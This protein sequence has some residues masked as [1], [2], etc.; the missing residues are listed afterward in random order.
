SSLRKGK[1]VMSKQN[2]VE[3]EDMVLLAKKIERHLKCEKATKLNLGFS[4]SRTSNWNKDENVE[5]KKKIDS[6]NGKHDAPNQS[7][8]IGDITI[9][10]EYSNKYSFEKDGRKLILTPLTSQKVYED[11]IKLQTKL[12]EEEK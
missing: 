4:S 7:K 2:Y 10:D 1:R 5:V 11:Q 3:L 6:S 12:R 9:H 8:G